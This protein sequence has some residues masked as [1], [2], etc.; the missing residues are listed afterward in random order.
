MTTTTTDDPTP[1]VTYDVSDY[2]GTAY[3]NLRLVLNPNIDND[4]DQVHPI[5]ST[6]GN[7][8][9]GCPEAVFHNR[10]LHLTGLDADYVAE[11]LEEY[12]REKEDDL[13]AIAEGFQGVEWSGSNWVGNWSQDARDLAEE[14]SDQLAEAIG[15]GGINRYFDASD[16]FADSPDLLDAENCDTLKEWA[17]IERD[18]A[19]GFG[20][21][22]AQDDTEDYLRSFLEKKAEELEEMEEF[23]QDDAEDLALCL[24]LLGN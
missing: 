19:S 16:W 15:Q 9:P 11:S 3:N 23:A 17:E 7:V 12:L 20:F 14:L 13:V 24:R 22:L 8:G 21:I 18:N 2:H 4:G 6:W 5:V 10:H 1:R